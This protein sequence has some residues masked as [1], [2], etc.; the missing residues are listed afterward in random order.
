[1]DHSF[2]SSRCSGKLR[3]RMSFALIVAGQNLHIHRLAEDTREHIILL[4][5][6]MAV[7]SSLT[8]DPVV[9]SE[10][11]WTIDAVLDPETFSQTDPNDAVRLSTRCNISGANSTSCAECALHSTIQLTT[12]ASKVESAV[13]S[14]PRLPG[15]HSYGVGW[16]F[17]FC[18][19]VLTLCPNHLKHC[20]I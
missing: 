3:P 17:R 1:M 4:L 6:R 12:S 7:D 16:P 15:L 13:I 14:C 8:A 19:K 18:C 11:Q 9:S 5:L 2:Q 20:L 10:L